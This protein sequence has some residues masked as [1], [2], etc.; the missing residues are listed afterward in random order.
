MRKQAHMAQAIKQYQSCIVGN[1]PGSNSAFSSYFLLSPINYYYRL[2]YASTVSVCSLR[3]LFRV[4]NPSPPPTQAG[5]LSLLS[6]NLA[7]GLVLLFP[8]LRQ[9]PCS[10]PL[11]T[12]GSGLVLL[13]PLIRFLL[14]STRPPPPQQHHHSHC[15]KESLIVRT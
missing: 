15:R 9:Q 2:I 7:W 4:P 11:S 10:P 5:A 13:L 12:T 14:S 1:V 6:S 3:P 8:Q